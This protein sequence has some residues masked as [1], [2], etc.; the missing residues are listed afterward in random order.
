[1]KRTAHTTSRRPIPLTKLIAT[2]LPLACLA[3]VCVQAQA[4][5][6]PVQKLETP[7]VEALGGVEELPEVVVTDNAESSEAQVSAAL[8]TARE[9]HPGSVATVSPE[10]MQLQKP[11][12]LGEVLQRIPG[13]TYVDEDGR[14]TRP[15]IGLRGLNPIRSEYVQFLLDGVPV[16][17]SLYSEQAGYYGPAA[18]RIAGIEV[19]KGGSSILF[20]PNTVGGVVNLITR[21]PSLLPFEAILDTR[22]DNWGDYSGNLFLS[23]THGALAYGVEYLHKGGDGFRDSLGHNID[24]LDIKLAIRFNENHSAQIRF[25]YYDE[26]AETPGG[27]L[28]DQF[29]SDVTQSNKPYDEFFGTR[30]AGDIRT[31]HQL[32]ENQRVDL[33]FYASTFE[34]DWFLQDFVD[35]TSAD[36]T[37]ADQNQQYLR[38]FTVVGFEPR[39]SLTYD[40]GESTGHELII[41][42]RIY[43]DQ[44]NSRTAVGNHGDSREGDNRLVAEADL[45]TLV[46]AGYV[47]N[48]FRITE[49]LSIVPGLRFEH[50]EQTRED[51]FNGSPEQSSDDY[52][53]LPG[54][55]VK[56]E[57][58]PKSLAY[59]NVTRSF[60]PPTFGDAFSPDILASNVDL[61][62]S[63]AW[64]YEAG[65]R[66]NPYPWLLVDFGG[67]YTDFK[68]QVVVAAG[69][70]GNFDTRSYGVEGLFEVGL[71]GL[72]HALQ[73][74]GEIYAGDHEVALTV[75]GTIVKSE[76]LD[77]PFQGNDLPY[78]P[79]QVVTFGVKYSFR[80]RFDLAFQGRYVGDRFTDQ[81][82]T[83][84]ENPAGTVGVLHDY[85]VFD[86][87]S[88]WKVSENVILNAGINN[89]FDEVYGTQRRTTQQKGIFP[90]P[91]RQFY[92]GAT[93]KF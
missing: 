80:D 76:F 86:I 7:A 10:Q 4:E 48:E 70:A 47:Q 46:F 39:Y 52:V 41:G 93:L 58:A 73:T 91:T 54:L 85:T 68:D 42:G 25:Q 19:F 32:T 3:P 37:L 38:D 20:G 92:V 30:I 11:S 16:Q 27:L 17:P 55:G 33:L 23:G 71:L 77:G 62:S 8:E 61:K 60:R 24:D 65:I 83:V 87:K 35:N 9:K 89:L 66:T 1:M 5:A 18:E 79:N 64:T 51:V 21:P 36:L 57:F 14:G 84:D 56:Y 44:V 90:G 22:F 15:D 59:A 72:T 43:Y 69:T 88:R 49:K 29:R 75:G 82:N 2:L 6:T 28:P 78:V 13:A 26:Q 74:N 67:F 12:N 50:I 45:T 53:W 31:K 40:L 34:R 63:T 81:L